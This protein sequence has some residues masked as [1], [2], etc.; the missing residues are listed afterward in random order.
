[1][2]AAAEPA[3]DQDALPTARFPESVTSLDRACR[4]VV[5][6][7]KRTNRLDDPA[8][9]PMFFERAVGPLAWDVDGHRYIDLIAGRGTVLLGYADREVDAAVRRAIGAGSM[10]PLTSPLHPRAAEQVCRAV[11]SVE[12][13]K[14]L[15]TG[16]EAVSAA[17]RLSRVWSG[18]RKIL[19]CGYHGW[20]GWF[21]E[22]RRPAAEHAAPVV[23]F[24]Y[25]LA[26]LES[27]LSRYAAETAAVIFSPEPSLLG[28]GHHQ[29][30]AD[31]VQ[32]HGVLLV[33]DELK[34][35]FR[36]GRAGYQGLAGLSPDLTALGKAIANGY[37]LAAIGGRRDVMEAERL[38]HI[39]GTYETENVGL[40]AAL[41]T[42]EL[43]EV[44]DYSQLFEMYRRLATE[45]N[46]AFRARGVA[47][48][49]LASQ[50][51]AQILFEDEAVARRFYR[52]A[53]A[54]GVLFN[55]F[56]DINLTFCHRE[57][58]EELL[59]ALLRTVQR[60]GA[61]GRGR[62]LS[63]EGVRRYL[64]RRGVAPPDGDALHPV[65]TAVHARTL[66]A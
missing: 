18:G 21:I 16:S 64:V 55:C 28:D 39:S 32:G 58:F 48:R 51:N 24:H 3:P 59:G 63:P 38:T 45:L 44:A 62:A 11:P 5:D 61:S 25:D 23:D 22:E 1:M 54:S 10:L 33:L 4:Y 60:L 27:L 49:C 29:A 26:A 37:V 2:R 8:Y 66:E 12:R 46:E 20:H 35:G 6:G 34:S 52:E 15:R 53:I 43:L 50:A 30:M 14:F 36:F 17:V 13:V 56:D 31:L 7:V 41:R 19:T 57:I 42:M 47:A 9:F 40:A 65:V